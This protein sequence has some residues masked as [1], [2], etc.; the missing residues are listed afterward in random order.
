[1]GLC[2]EG[3]SPFSVFASLHPYGSLFP[4]VKHRQEG[5][6]ESH[7]NLGDL[8]FGDSIESSQYPKPFYHRVMFSARP[9]FISY[10]IFKSWY[11][12][13]PHPIFIEQLSLWVTFYLPMVL[14]CFP[15]LGT[16]NSMTCPGQI[17]LSYFP[18][19][20]LSWCQLGGLTASQKPS[21]LASLTLPSL[22][23][24]SSYKSYSH[25][26]EFPS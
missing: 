19:W 7:P 14:A 6:Y 1:M 11:S 25:N 24:S 8:Q 23:P 21:Q 5:V 9:Y 18:S 4:L 17:F 26:L 10:L 15:M 13:G 22:S 3:W 16:S 12:L 2:E 20:L